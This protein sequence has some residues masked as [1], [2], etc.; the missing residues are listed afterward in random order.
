MT[1][2]LV[3]SGGAAFGMANAGILAALE[4]Q[5]LKP[6]YIAGSSMGAIVAGLY[7]TGLSGKDIC[8][9]AED[10]EL[11]D[12]ASIS[13]EPLKDGLHGGILTQAIR[14]HL[15]PYIGS[16]TIGDCQIPFVCIAGKINEPIKWQKIISEGF[17]EHAMECVEM[18]LFEAKTLLIDALMASSAI[19]VV[20]SPVDIE[21]NQFVHLCHFG[22]VPSRTLGQEYEPDVIIGTSTN[23][24][25]HFLEKLLPSSW[26]QF[27]KDGESYMQESLDACDI[28]I[29]PEMV[30]LPFRF[31][32]AE[33]FIEAGKIATQAHMTEITRLL[34]S[35]V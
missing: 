10:I 15:D 23:P 28:V 4:E 29:E 27:I 6:D 3:L 18:H 30:E 12:V 26:Q 14:R 32:K 8:K 17:T 22:A 9:I 20:F 21:G 31:D 34:Q 19:P 16:K 1:W 25:M 24:R 35:D 5:S 7:A 2:G 13:K 11:I 33:K